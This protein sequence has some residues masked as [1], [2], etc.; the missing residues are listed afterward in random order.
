[1]RNK[2]VLYV[3]VSLFALLTTCLLFNKHLMRAIIHQS[4]TIGDANNSAFDT[5]PNG[6]YHPWLLG[7]QQ[8][9]EIPKAYTSEM[10]RLKTT[11]FLVCTDSVLLTERYW[12]GYDRDSVSNVF[13]ITKSIVSMLIGQAVEEGYIG[14]IDDKVVKYLPEFNHGNNDKISIEDLL[15]M[16]SGLD[17]D[18]WDK[19]LFSPIA[20]LYYGQDVAQQAYDLSGVKEP[21]ITFDYQSCNTQLLGLILEKTTKMPLSYYAASRLWVPL[22]TRSHAL[23]GIDDEGNTKA[24]CCFNTVARDIARVG[25]LILNEGRWNGLQLIPGNYLAVATSAVANCVPGDKDE[26]YG[27]QFWLTSHKG[28]KI[29]YARG[30]LGQYL[31][32]IPSKKLII[33]RFGHSRDEQ[34]INGNPADLFTWI[35]AGIDIYELSKN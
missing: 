30:I 19:G 10:K 17:W 28:L 23:W 22:G 8:M 12:Q 1:M 25:Q 5:V 4:P 2:T 7:Q 33:V 14:S 29:V 15:S 27:Y 24:Y 6:V 11:A 31:I 16:R 26:A 18:E 34:I 35:D 21:G 32:M 13:S 20:K 9:I 3:G